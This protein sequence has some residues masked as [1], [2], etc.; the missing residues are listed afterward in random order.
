MNI[1]FLRRV[2]AVGALLVSASVV[3]AAQEAISPQ[4]TYVLLFARFEDHT[5][6]NFLFDRLE[7][8]LP[9]LEKYRK[10]F[11]QY[12]ISCVFE[13]SGAA[14]QV[15]SDAGESSPVLKQLK[16]AQAKGL[17]EIGYIGDAEP[18]YHHRPTPNFLLAATPEAR[19]QA[20][21]QTTDE[22]LTQYKDPV[23]GDSF[24]ALSGGLKRVQEVFGPVAIAGGLDQRLGAESV[25][26]HLL[27][28]YA[29]QSIV[30]ALPPG[31]PER[32]IEGYAVET[33][34]FTDYMSP[35]PNTSPEMFWENDILHAADTTGG[36]MRVFSTDE[37]PKAFKEAIGKI[38][39]AHVRVVHM[40][41]L[42][43][44]RYLRK[45]PDGTRLDPL[46]WA[47][48]RPDNPAVT[49]NMSMFAQENE[50]HAGFVQEETNLQWLLKEF[51][52]TVPGSRFVSA[53]ELKGMVDPVD[54]SSVS[55]A[56]LREA[57][58]D[59]L[60]A[61]KQN[62]TSM[63]NY[64]HAGEHYFSLADMFMLFANSFEEM[65]DG[66]LPDNVKLTPVYGPLGMEEAIGPGGKDVT[67]AGVIRAGAQIAP[68][69]RDS[70]WKPL[71]SNVVPVFATV[72][73]ARLNAGQ[74]LRLM[75]EAYLNPT[76]GKLK[77]PS[78]YMYTAAGDIYPRN[79]ARTD[80]G[81]VWTFR[82]A[83]LRIEHTEGQHGMR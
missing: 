31:N 25:S 83:P 40:E 53:G 5:H 71:P 51:F 29:P 41:L 6:P 68:A 28:K 47:Y 44:L 72:D 59:L 2:L 16:N 13:F 81:E 42:N 12:K 39:H 32:G 79:T 65:R 63:G 1:G 22:F 76:G 77:V 56:E 21:Y 3:R 43:Y 45:R 35:L 18:T 33:Q 15:I 73:E 66:K 38:D 36:G 27:R 61:C 37:D 30:F 50:V 74:L 14:A 17:V 64:A 8:A 78:S 70:E 11:P 24:P 75:A 7:R 67:T 60:A 80:G 49:V 19:W 26:V 58:T 54:G 23:T 57:A 52:P 82:P 9:L 48:N 10:D 20:R 46:D 4:P 69:L 55:A 62:G 34:R